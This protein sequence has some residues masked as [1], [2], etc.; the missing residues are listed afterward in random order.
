MELKKCMS[1]DIIIKLQKG[2]VPIILPTFYLF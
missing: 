1:H 2:Q